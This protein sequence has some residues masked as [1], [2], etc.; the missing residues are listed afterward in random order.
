[1][2]IAPDDVPLS[3]SY[4]TAPEL[5]PPET[6]DVAAATGCRLVG[7]R[8]LGGQPTGE[9]PPIMIDG[10]IRRE[11]LRRLGDTGVAVLDASTARLIADTRIADFGRF[12]DVA[13]ELGARHV[14]ASG[15]DPDE[16]RLV[17]HFAQLCDAAAARGLTVDIEFVPW[18]SIA[19][20][21]AARRIVVASG[22]N[23]LGIVVDALH[24]DRSRGSL[25]ELA[26]VPPERLRYM[27]ICDAPAAWS[28][29]PASL[30]HVAV[31]ERL[32]PGE[33]GIDLV[34]LLR[35]LPRGI[36]LALEIPTEALARTMDAR[37]RVT[38]AVA[39]TRR[40]VA[41]AYADDRA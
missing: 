18:M 3:L 20:L 22:R 30:L 39:A 8:L 13:A 26:G 9:L 34:G 19:D 4:Y 10:A 29:D 16:G 12:L 17:E 25:D 38:R 14:L 7:V 1:M 35:T 33:G 41:A 24:F 40:V 11:T 21:A 27:Q 23:N 2:M 28:A 36:P 37:A 15:N 32:F 31:K 6:V 5:S